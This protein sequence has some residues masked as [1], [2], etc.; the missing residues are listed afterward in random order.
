MEGNSGTKMLTFTVTLSQASIYPVTFNIKTVDGMAVAGSDYVAK[1]LTGVTIPAGQTSKT[2]SI[3]TN[4]DTQV[5]GNETLFVQL[6][7][8]S[9]PVTDGQARG[10]LIN[11][12]GP[13]LSIGDV[14]VTEGNSGTKLMTFV[15]SLSQVAPAKVTFNFAT[16]ADTASAGSDFDPVSVTGLAIPQGQLSRM[17]SVVVRGDTNV[18]PNEVLRGNISLGNVSIVDGVGI[19]TITNDD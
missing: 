2:F 4:G 14:S 18:E 13:V 7:N 9:V 6:S 17:V 5:E 3:L 8:A 15:V 11:D 10:M 16:A 1:T 12:D 19:G